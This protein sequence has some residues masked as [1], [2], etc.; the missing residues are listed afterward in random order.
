LLPSA[1]DEQV[2]PASVAGFVD[3]IEAEPLGRAAVA[4]GAGRARLEDRVDHGVGISVMAQVGA[5]VQAGE[6]VLVLRHR[7]G[8]GLD[9]AL[10]LV[11]QAVRIGGTPPSPTPLVLE[12]V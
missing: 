11:R 8:R 12:I 3:A 9:E 7:G 2:V 4:L 1:P 5:E 6:P 10:P